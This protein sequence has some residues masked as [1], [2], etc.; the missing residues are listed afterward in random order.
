MLGATQQFTRQLNL[1]SPFFL[2]GTTWL[3]RWCSNPHFTDEE[4]NLKEASCNCSS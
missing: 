2:L 3:G 4:M 1:G